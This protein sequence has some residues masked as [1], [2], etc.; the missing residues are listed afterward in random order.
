[1]LSEEHK[2]TLEAYSDGI[3]D[4]V[5]GTSFWDEGRSSKLLPPEFYAFGLS[6][7]SQWR[8]WEPSDTLAL[9]KYKSFY[10]S[11]NWM[12]DLARESLR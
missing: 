11:W 9:L 7:L 1:M 4:C 12:N 2:A 3:N 10:L 5:F 8:P 6:D